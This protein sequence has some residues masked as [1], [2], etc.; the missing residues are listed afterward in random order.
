MATLLASVIAG[1]SRRIDNLQNRKA[2]QELQGL[3]N[4]QLKDI[5]IAR[6]EIP[7]VVNY[8]RYH[9]SLDSKTTVKNQAK[10]IYELKRYSDRQL[11]D[12]NISRSEIE[13]VVKFGR[14]GNA[15]GV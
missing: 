13:Q 14:P 12:L 7:H 6:S 11:K 1:I 2:I 15:L 5:G 9:Q 8:G 10:A 3:S 4:R